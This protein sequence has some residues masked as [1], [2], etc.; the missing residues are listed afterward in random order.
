MKQRYPPQTGAYIND[1]DTSDGKDRVKTPHL[2]VLIG[3]FISAIF[4]LFIIY[5]NIPAFEKQHK[6]RLKLPTSFQDVKDISEMLSVYTESNYFSV[7]AAFGAV[8]LFLQTFT[9]PGS[10]FLSFL[11]GAL[12][13][14]IVG[15]PLVCLMAT[16]GATGA[17]ALSYYI[18]GNFVRKRFPDRLAY[19][20]S[21]LTKHRSHILN[22]ILFLRI[23][24]FL[25]NWFV[26]LASPLLGVGLKEFMIG[27]FFGVMPQT[28]F[29]VKA[30]TTL[31]KSVELRGP[32]DI[33]DTT[34]IITITIFALL[35][36][37]P[38]LAPVQRF[39]DRLLN[40]T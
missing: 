35:S 29:A 38:T 16:F 37:L 15:V 4:I 19:F 9:I 33:F 6:E 30:G 7:M 24:P 21:E 1:L 11:A 2:S 13:D 10:I 14:S 40:K 27:T 5:I 17:Y 3:L 34:A 18:I 32:Q 39:L 20:A 25:P 26:N 23:T 12:F 31:Q 36:V 8:Y 22:Y 28:Y